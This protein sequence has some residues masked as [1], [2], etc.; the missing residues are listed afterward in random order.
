M[1]AC[2]ARRLGSSLGLASCGRTASAQGFSN[3]AIA[4]ERGTTERATEIQLRN[5][6]RALGV[7]DDPNVNPR[8]EAVR[9]YLSATGVAI[10]G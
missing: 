3:D 4:R 7:D 8:V 2:L 9:R 6:Y 10:G 1:H 5:I